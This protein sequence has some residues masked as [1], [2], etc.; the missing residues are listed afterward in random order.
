[1]FVSDWKEVMFWDVSGKVGV[2]NANNL[3]VSSVVSLM[4]PIGRGVG[5]NSNGGGYWAMV[6]YFLENEFLVYGDRTIGLV[7]LFENQ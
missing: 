4:G 3:G 6:S 5:G 2:F 1:M 7:S